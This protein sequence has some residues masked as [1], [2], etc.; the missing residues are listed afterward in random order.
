M[1]V[2]IEKVRSPAQ[3][4]AVSTLVWEFFDFLRT[5]YQ[6]MLGEIDAYIAK[7]NVAGD[8]ADFA[9][10]FLPPKGECLVGL[11]D[12]QPVGM[13]MLKPHDDKTCEMNRMYVRDTA[14]GHGIGRQLADALIAEARALDYRSVRL[15]ALYRHTEALPLYESLG[16]VRFHDA[17]PHDTDARVIHMQLAL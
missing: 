8:L 6:D 2:A 9:Q 4:D 16:F 1:N 11:L 17:D 7:Q 3:I 10:V 15:S 12:D 5:R 13:V 14:R